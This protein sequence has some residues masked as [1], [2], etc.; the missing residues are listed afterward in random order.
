MSYFFYDLYSVL[1]GP[2]FVFSLLIFAAGCL[3]RIIQFA[4]FTRRI[5]SH[6]KPASNPVTDDRAILFREKPGI[7]KVFISLKLKIKRTIFGTNPVMGIV[8]LVFHILIFVTPVF[9]SAHNILSDHY[10]GISLFVLP[11]KLMN[12]FTVCIIMICLFFLMR[13][14]LSPRVRLLSTINDYFILLLVMIPFISAFNAYHQFFNYRTC[15]LIHIISGEIAIMAVP[16]TRLGHMP[17]LIF[18]R[19]F[20]SGEY[21]WKPGNRTW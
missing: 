14:I 16:F 19:F 15:L 8:S 12:G 21:N 7:E 3:Y 10:F 4:R 9:L 11:D 5:N 18:S 2:V 17:F 20:I 1:C 13:R 6:Y